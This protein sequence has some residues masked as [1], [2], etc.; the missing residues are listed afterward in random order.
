MVNLVVLV[1]VF[2]TTPAEFEREKEEAAAL[3]NG[4][5]EQTDEISNMGAHAQ[6]LG[7]SIEMEGS[8]RPRRRSVSRTMPK[9]SKYP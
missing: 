7:E 1:A 3:S 4:A 8:G 2:H 6:V 9:S 5:D